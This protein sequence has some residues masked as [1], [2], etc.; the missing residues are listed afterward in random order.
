M[1]IPKLKSEWEG[2]RGYISMTWDK[3]SEDELVRLEGNFVSL[4]SLI[5]EKY[6]EP[7]EQIEN[8]IHE[9]FELYQ[10]KKAA[11]KEDIAE[12]KENIGE[13]S[14]RILKGIKDKSAEYSESVKNR[15]N[16]IKKDNIDP[17]VEKSESYIKLHP[18]TAVLGALGVGLL[19]GGIF[20]LLARS[21]D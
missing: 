16:E 19:V 8:K 18:F 1:D 9:L 17:Y 12:L 21:K 3:V 6:K 11:L 2:F 14:S 20:G 7:K 15:Y 5:A 13:R 10:S 4:V